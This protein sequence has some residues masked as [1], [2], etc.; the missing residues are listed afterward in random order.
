MRIHPL[1]PEDDRARFESG[2][3]VLDRFLREFALQNARRHAIGQT[4]VAEESGVVLGFLTVAACSLRADDLPAER[5]SSLPAYPLPALRIARL[6]VDRRVQ[7]HGIGTALVVAA[8]DIALEMADRVG[9]VGIV[10]DAK[11]QA[12]GFYERFG[13]VAL[14]AVRGRSAAR[15]RQATL[16]LPLRAVR[17]AAG[18]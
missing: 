9:C 6:A 4:Y 3:A 14:D 12:E 10:A 17:E 2:D 7:R 8:C 5:R 16:F 13:F 1:R 15:P 18:E 11:P